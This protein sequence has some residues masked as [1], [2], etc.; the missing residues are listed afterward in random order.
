V[1]IIG[2]IVEPAAGFLSISVADHLHRRAVGTEVVGDE[3]ICAIMAFH[4][5]P[6][7]FQGCLAIMALCDQAFQDVPL[8]IH[9]PP[10]VVHLAVDLH[11]HLIQVPLPI[12]I[13]AL[14]ADPFLAD[15]SGKQRA[16]SVPP[17]PNR[18]V[19]DI[20]AAFV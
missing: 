19:A 14:L 1:W 15:L 7:E 6:E 10:K 5:L 3:D 2:S 4:A 11:E 9:S 20:D 17:K 8:V 16:K 12:W 13:C 18:F